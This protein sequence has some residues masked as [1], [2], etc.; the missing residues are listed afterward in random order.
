MKLKL[1]KRIALLL[2]LCIAAIGGGALAS[3]GSRTIRINPADMDSRIFEGWGTSLCWWANRIGYSDTLAQQSA[4][5]FFSPQGLDMNIMRYNI[6]GGDDPTHRHITRTDSAVP[7]WLVWDDDAQAYL[8]DYEADHRQLN[9]LKRAA[10]AAGS[11]ALVELFSNSPP[12]F[13]TVSGCTSGAANAADNNLRPD[14]CDDFAQYLAHVT[15]YIQ[16]ELSIPVVSLSPMNEPDTEYWQANSWKQEGCHTD[17]G[18]AQSDVIVA[19][20]R[21]LRGSRSA[22]VIIAASDETSPQKQIAEYHAYS[23]E[24]RAAIGRI[25][26]HTYNEK[27][28]RELGQLARKEN[29]S[30]WMS[31]VDGGETAGQRAGE[32]GAA[33]W[34]GGK[35]I[36]D[37]NQLMP[38]AWVAWQVIDNHIS[39]AGFAGNKDTGMVDLN[40]GYWGF[41]VADHDRESIILTQKYY[42]MGQFSRYIHPGSR[43]IPCTNS[44]IAAYDQTRGE[45]AIVAVQAGA[46]ERTLTLDLS[47]FSGT[48]AQAQAIRTSGS[49]ANG[50]HWAQLPPVSISGGKMTATLKGHSITTFIIPD[51]QI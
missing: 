42:A 2:C 43:I 4:D 28:R 26:T 29:F 35:I 45:L 5:L 8:Y 27:G 16:H 46:G 31:E 38:T 25:N 18:T 41:A 24:A 6:G 11:S 13:M 20:A 21:A 23:P 12:Y 10:D 51:V 22:N 49:M 33:L 3:M 7:G 17:P 50:E 36:S 40:A 19:A 39:E 9:V 30:L 37:I 15:D 47:A 34:L 14:C 44:V 32:M 48:G 1:K